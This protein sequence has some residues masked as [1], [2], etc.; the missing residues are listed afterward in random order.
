MAR[1]I[2]TTVRVFASDAPRLL[3][4]GSLITATADAEVRH[5]V[6]R[7]RPSALSIDY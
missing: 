6:R 2:R 4:F 7:R 1:S 5:Y 3:T